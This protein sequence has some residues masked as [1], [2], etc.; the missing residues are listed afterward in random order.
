[1]SVYLAHAI[2]CEL[3]VSLVVQENVVQL[4]VTV[5][6]SFFVQ[7]VQSDT[8]FSSI[9]SEE[10]KKRNLEIAVSDVSAKEIIMKL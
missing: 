1:M 10:K 3:D 2:V 8:N 9:K 4:Q 7:E 6:D 5:D